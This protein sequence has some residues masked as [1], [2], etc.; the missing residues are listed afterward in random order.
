MIAKSYWRLSPL[1]P[2]LP[3]GVNPKSPEIVVYGVAPAQVVCSTA[4]NNDYAT[5]KGGVI[6]MADWGEALIS[7]G[8]ERQK[9]LEAATEALR[10]ELEQLA[11]KVVRL[12][13][14]LSKRARRRK[15]HKR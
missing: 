5:T 13:E 1:A 11:T 2:T 6:E 9:K 3:A 14:R 15:R 4:R 12:P 8:P 10:E 7:E